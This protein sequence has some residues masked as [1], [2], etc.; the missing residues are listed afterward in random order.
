MAVKMYK[1]QRALKLP[2]SLSALMREGETWIEV[3]NQ[4]SSDLKELLYT[5]A[6]CF[7]KEFGFGPAYVY[8]NKNDSVYRAFLFIKEG[9]LIGGCAFHSL[10]N[11]DPD[12][13]CLQWAWLIPS[14]RRQGHFQKLW[15]SFTSDLNKIA[16]GC[17]ISEPMQAF[18]EKQQDWQ[19]MHDGDL[20]AESGTLF[21][22]KN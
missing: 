1:C 3:N 10:D 8:P 17:P 5:F 11:V 15:E 9:K 6:T 21:L 4:S 22:E 2:A 16:I 7:T 14:E 12:I 20:T 19:I 18:I 13:C